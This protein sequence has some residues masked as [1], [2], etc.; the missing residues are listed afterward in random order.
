MQKVIK[1]EN[2]HNFESIAQLK[3]KLGASESLQWVLQD[4]KSFT[5]CISK[6]D[7]IHINSQI[8]FANK[9]AN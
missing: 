4:R 5:K 9:F 8:L 7:E 3:M 1:Y 2:S 6:I